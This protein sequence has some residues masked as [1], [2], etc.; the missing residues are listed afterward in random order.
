M[1]GHR[2]LWAVH[3][4]FKSWVH[5]DSTLHHNPFFKSISSWIRG[6]TR[7]CRSKHGRHLGVDTAMSQ[8]QRWTVHKGTCKL[9]PY[10]VVPA[11]ME[12]HI[13][14]RHGVPF[15]PSAWN[16]GR[17]VV[18]ERASDTLCQ[19][20]QESDPKSVRSVLSHTWVSLCLVLIRYP[21]HQRW[22]KSC[23]E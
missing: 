13:P 14:G 12:A 19:W 3:V 9:K 7:C 15:G 1:S 22:K 2:T 16:W 23:M 4:S 20:V 5:S 11:W 10:S 21:Q 8:G 6:D 17:L 18:R